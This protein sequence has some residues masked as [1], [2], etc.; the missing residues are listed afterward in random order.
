M[1]RTAGHK[2]GVEKMAQI[3]FASSEAGVS[4]LTLYAF[5]A[6]N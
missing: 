5:S 4:N 1:E 3:V 6:E 2:V